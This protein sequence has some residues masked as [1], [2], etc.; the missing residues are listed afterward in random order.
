MTRR[1]LD[2]VHLFLSKLNIS[3]LLQEVTPCDGAFHIYTKGYLLEEQKK[4]KKK[5]IGL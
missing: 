1:E 4:K 5:Q 2:D 3:R